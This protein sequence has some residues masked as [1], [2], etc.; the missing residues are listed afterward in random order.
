MEDSSKTSKHVQVTGKQFQSNRNDRN[1][2]SIQVSCIQAIYDILIQQLPNLWRLGQSYF[3]GQLHV[4]VDVEKQI[5]FK[6]KK[7][8]KIFNLSLKY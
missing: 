5:P 4:A 6:V 3:S 7:K 2:T 1:N 8:L